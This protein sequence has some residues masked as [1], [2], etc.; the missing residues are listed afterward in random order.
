MECGC[1]KFSGVLDVLRAEVIQYNIAFHVTNLC[2]NCC[3]PMCLQKVFNILYA[4]E[5]FHLSIQ[6]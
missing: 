4:P 6:L 5:N 1:E 2:L 3:Y